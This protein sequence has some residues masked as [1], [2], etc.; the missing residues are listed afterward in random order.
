MKQLLSLLILLCLEKAVHAQYIY[1]IKAD[2]VKI[3]NTCDTAELIIE[4]H[5]QNV[6]G[7]LFNKGRGRTEFRRA[8]SLSDSSLLLGGDTL[9][10]RGNTNANNGVSMD[11]KTVQLGQP[12]GATGNPAALFSNREIPM[13]GNYI[14]F[15][16]SGKIGIGTNAPHTLL[17]INTSQTS[18][19]PSAVLDGAYF[20][21]LIS[22][23]H[24]VAG[25]CTTESAILTTGNSNII[26]GRF[27]L[28]KA[29]GGT[30]NPLAVQQGDVIGDF[31]AG[32]YDGTSMI[33]RGLLRF[34]I[35]GAVSMGN[36]PTALI[37]YNGT[38]STIERMRL[39][40]AGN[41]GL[42][43]TNP[44]DKLHVVGTVKITD[45]LKL[46]NIISQT[47]TVNLKPVVI[48]ASGN[49]F[50]MSG[51]N[52][53]AS[54]KSATVTAGS[55]TVPA[56]ID[57]VFVNYSGGTATVSLPSGTLDREITIKNLSTTN[58]V[59][60]SGLDASESNTVAARGA[61]TVKYTGS[62]WVGISKY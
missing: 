26:H 19:A 55:Y 48:D 10:L 33:L 34:S 59:A 30:N 15:T 21:Q 54:R 40:S 18:I 1:T 51:W 3:T 16:G 6:S 27:I 42:G 22:T 61:I 57:V 24:S 5:T 38:T 46:P 31:G 44:S 41:L 8:V 56:D 62:A 7:F 12:V 50:K 58:S 39:S 23:D 2:S 60:L 28:T 53:S 49:V 52:V 47:D 25:C 4:N 43:T 29:R 13:N 35:D 9:V 45:T 17:H 37:F 36:L 32:A 20:G 11:A 14:G